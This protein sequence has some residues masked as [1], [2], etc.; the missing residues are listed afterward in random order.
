[1]KFVDFTRIS[2]HGGRGG[3]GCLSFRREK[4]IPKGGP[5]GADGG[6]GGDIILEA[7]PGALTLADFE[8]EKKF[9]AGN[10]EPGKGGMK[11]GGA[12]K[13]KIVI[14]P[15]G[16]IVYDD[17]T[18]EILADLVEPGDRLIAAKGGR[19]GRGN[20]HFANSV[21]KSPRFA[22]KGDEGEAR[23]LLLELKL[24]ADV[25]LVG[26]PNAGKSSLLGAISSARPKVAG[27]PFTTLSPNLGVLSVDD[28][29]IVIADVPGLIEGAH[30]NKGLGVYFLRH[31]ERTRFLVHVLDLSAGTVDDVIE[32]W[33]ILRNE[34]EAYSNSEES[35]LPGYHRQ[36][37]LLRPYIVV[38][39]KI[40]LENAAN[41]DAPIRSFMEEQAIPYFSVSALSGEGIPEFIQLIAD[42]ARENPRHEGETRLAPLVVD[43]QEP[44]RWRR[45]LEPVSI[46]RLG[47]GGGFRVVHANLEKTLLRYDFEQ[48][49]ALP[50]FAR[51]V[52]KFRIEERLEE[53]G[54]VKGDKVYIG[55][56]EFDFEPD[57]AGASHS[58]KS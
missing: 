48:E 8:Y 49:D 7:A 23:T 37:L 26:V 24:I 17:D 43:I 53:M 10:G 52:K 33:R 28:Q 27:Y 34:F 56:H 30:E 36:D 31:V 57:M 25:G 40:D 3:N 18:G 29:K 44:R 16:T 58:Q 19:P 6:R 54:A 11:S 47:D 50:K 46:I 32:Q 1:M 38:G 2:V 4:F 51:L 5:D 22:E 12:G 55:D 9:Q 35:G 13:D 21:R 45:K 15:C 14:V 20:A 39:N 42:S 41:N